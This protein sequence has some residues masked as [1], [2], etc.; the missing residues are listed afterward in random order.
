MGGA[1][2]GDNTGTT[3]TRPDIANCARCKKKLQSAMRKR[4]RVDVTKLAATRR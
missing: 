4:Q 2:C 1:L 3:T